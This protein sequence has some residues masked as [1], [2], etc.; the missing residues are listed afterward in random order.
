MESSKSYAEPLKPAYELRKSHFTV[1][2]NISILGGSRHPNCSDKICSNNESLKGG[3]CVSW[4][5]ED[6]DT[7]TPL[8][9]FSYQ[10][11]FIFFLV[12]I[13]LVFAVIHQT[14]TN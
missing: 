8:Y 10:F 4:F 11:I 1:F 5:P 9:Y 14:S 13:V 2:G 7:E 12:I 3:G 6:S